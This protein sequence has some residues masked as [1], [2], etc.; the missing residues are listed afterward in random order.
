MPELSFRTEFIN[1]TYLFFRFHTSQ[2]DMVTKFINANH[3]PY[4]KKKIL[5]CTGGG[6][7]KYKSEL[8]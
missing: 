5:R 6:A 8:L 3:F 2:I 4:D 7:Y 1:G